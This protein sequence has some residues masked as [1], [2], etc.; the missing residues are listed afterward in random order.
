MAEHRE[1]PIDTVGSLSHCRSLLKEY[2]DIL[3]DCLRKGNQQDDPQALMLIRGFDFGIR[4]VQGMAT[5]IEADQDNVL[6]ACMLCRPFYETAV[7]LLWAARMH[8]GWQRLQVHWA[9][10]DLT[11]AREAEQMP[12][13]TGHA[14]TIQARREEAL[15][16]CE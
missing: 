7:R 15:R 2:R 13:M 14:K 8:N 11:W 9:K 1:K 4:T 3:D 6:L 5:L 12:S 16:A 10:Q